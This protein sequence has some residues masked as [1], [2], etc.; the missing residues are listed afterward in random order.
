M[1]NRTEFPLRTFIERTLGPGRYYRGLADRMLED[2]PTPP[3]FRPTGGRVDLYA[4]EELGATIGHIGG[5]A[6]ADF[7]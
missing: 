2:L 6:R 7:C 4:R 1:C 5:L 3:V